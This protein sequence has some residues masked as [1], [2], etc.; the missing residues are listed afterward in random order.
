MKK[1]LIF[2][3]L[4]VFA[5]T[6]ADAQIF[7]NQKKRA[8]ERAKR[9]AQNK[10]QNKVDRT[11]DEAVDDAFESIGSLFKK[12]K[13]KQDTNNSSNEGDNAKETD[14]ADQAMG[15]VMDMLGGGKSPAE[16]GLPNSYAFDTKVRM[17]MTSINKRGKEDTG[18]LNM[19]LADGKDYM[20]YDMEEENGGFAV[21][22]MERMKMVAV[23]TEEES[24]MNMATVMDM[25]STLAAASQYQ[26]EEEVDDRD[27]SSFKVT[28]TGKT[29]T[30]AG[31]QCTQYIIEGDDAEGE[32]WKA[33]DF[34]KMNLMKMGA[35]MSQMMQQNKDMQMP[36]E[37]VELLQ[38][39][40]AFESNFYDKKSKERSIMV[41]EEVKS[42]SSSVDLTQYKLMDMGRFMKN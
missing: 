27:Y 26:T 8:E 2:L 4:A 14:E 20:G 42:E 40:F 29:K 41:V 16:A 3:L 19:L 21:M 15:S 18:T 7:K 28:K 36:T 17:R 34:N 6:T 32:V 24:G 10:A 39:G 38:D 22:D 35:S 33:K 12:K 25:E 13:K 37:L 30:I 23:V 9:R 11:V 1:A 5:C 31:Y